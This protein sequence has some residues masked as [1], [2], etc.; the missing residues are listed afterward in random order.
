MSWQ[1]SGFRLGWGQ[2]RLSADAHTPQP[3]GTFLAD[4]LEK[5]PRE[6]YLDMLRKTL[7]QTQGIAPAKFYTST[8]R[9]DPHKDMGGERTL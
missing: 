2:K 3:I 6:L 1:I 8:V 4:M 9:A 7:C 5:A